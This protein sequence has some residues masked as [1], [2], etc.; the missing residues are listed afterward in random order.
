MVQI[1][2]SSL[3]SLSF[4]V[5]WFYLDPL[6]RCIHRHEIIHKMIRFSR[7]CVSSFHR[8]AYHAY[9]LCIDYS[10]SNV[11]PGQVHSLQTVLFPDN[12]P[13][14]NRWRPIL[15]ASPYASFNF[16]AMKTWGGE[17]SAFTNIHRLHRRTCTH[18]KTHKLQLLYGSTAHFTR[19][20]FYQLAK[21]WALNICTAH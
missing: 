13:S 21:H 19:I 12:R 20:F 7:I 9:L 3:H 8:V 2:V 16:A 5:R 6:R 14:T 17:S 15:R 1:S 4:L 11:V 18:E 10:F